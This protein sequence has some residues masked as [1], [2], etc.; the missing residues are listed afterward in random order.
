MM[1]GL[2]LFA[3]KAF[4]LASL[5]TCEAT[6]TPVVTIDFQNNLPL[7]T[8]SLDH[9][10][11][12]QF[13]TSTHVSHGPDE[14]LTT[15]GITESDIQASFDLNF[16]LI[17]NTF[18]RDTCLSLATVNILVKYTPTVHI[19]KNYAPNS[20]RYKTTWEHEM[21][22]VGADVITLEEYVPYYK[23]L[24]EYTVSGFRTIGPLNPEQNEKTQK[25]ITAHLQQTLEQA[26]AQM[27]KARIQ[28][29]QSIDTREEY[30]RL[31]NLCPGE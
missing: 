30:M 14:I 22:H 24:M 9:T 12:G 23:K 6:Q 18:S 15:G 19:A 13:Q 4:M 25:E 16:N 27:D 31:S 26:T 21:R 5:M 8:N 29:Q 20:C 11:L 2:E 7:L 28:R 10:Q 1:A 3:A 17:T